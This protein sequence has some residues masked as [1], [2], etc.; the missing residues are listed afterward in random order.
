MWQA[1][2]TGLVRFKG[3]QEKAMEGR[4]DSK[5]VLGGPSR[6]RLVA[7]RG[8]LACGRTKQGFLR[9]SGDKLRPPGVMTTASLL[10]PVTIP[11]ITFS[12]N[13]PVSML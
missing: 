8:E 13:F 7:V 2:R 9:N 12:I 6:K 11:T 4:E 3:E 1:V 10:P 5:P